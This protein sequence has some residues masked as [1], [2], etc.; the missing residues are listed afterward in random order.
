MFKTIVM[1][2]T[3]YIVY[4]CNYITILRSSEQE[5]EVIQPEENLFL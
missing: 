2:K 1:F 4:S 5:D 3:L